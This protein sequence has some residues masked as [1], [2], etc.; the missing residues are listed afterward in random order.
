MGLRK[1][2][3]AVKYLILYAVIFFAVPVTFSVASNLEVERYINPSS[4]VAGEWANVEIIVQGFEV[5]LE[6]PVPFDGV[7]IIDQSRSM[8]GSDPHDKR[9]AAAKTF[10]GGAGAETRVAIVTISDEGRM[11]QSLTSNRQTLINK[12]N[13]LDGREGGATNI[14]DAMIKAQEELIS[15]GIEIRKKVIVLLTDGYPTPDTDDQE[16]AI[17]DE[18]LPEANHYDIRYYTVGLG[19]WADRVL[20]ELI[21]DRTGGFY[22][23]T[24][25]E[26]LADI[27]VYIGDE[28]ARRVCPRQVVVK[29]RVNPQLTVRQGSLSWQPDLYTISEAQQD[30][31]YNTGRINVEMGELGPNEHRSLTF[32]V[33]ALCLHPDSEQDRVEIPVGRNG[34]KIEYTLGNVTGEVQIPQRIL[35]CLKPGEIEIRKGFD[36]ATSIC[37]LAVKSKYLDLPDRD[38]TIRNIRIF[39]APSLYFQP[40]IRSIRP[41]PIH[42]FPSARVDYIYWSIPRL[43]PG[44]EWFAV[45]ELIPRACSP[46]HENPF[47][48]NE[49]KELGPAP[50]WFSYISPDGMLKREELPQE[51]VDLVYIEECDGRPDLFITPAV[52]LHEFNYKPINPREYVPPEYESEAIWIDSEVNGFVQDWTDLDHVQASLHGTYITYPQQ[53]KV[54][55]QGDPFPLGRRNVVYALVYNKGLQSSPPTQAMLFAHNWIMRSWDLVAEISIPPIQAWGEVLI[56]FELPQMTLKNWY[57]FPYGVPIQKTLSVL[58]SHDRE[59]CSLTSEDFE[60]LP[61]LDRFKLDKTPRGLSVALVSALRSDRRLSSWW[62][63]TFATLKISIVPVSLERHT[64][65]NSATEKVIVSNPPQLG[66]HRPPP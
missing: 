10:L 31:F 29:E 18:I 26:G 14:R 24:T 20:L 51:M 48:I 33:G 15:N 65:N 56:K 62:R 11:V 6:E 41:A 27:Y 19:D 34:A 49:T 30:D 43:E 53:I 60:K 17:L 5:L 2:H 12:I 7:L 45:F 4:I 28:A 55:G 35:E 66:R 23:P 63:T 59:F 9:L 36:P 1:K 64:N 47:Q 40:L 37:T 44:A 8:D 39:E 50:G 25:P 58:C 16:N 46:M 54:K 52:T 13:G 61:A 38:N 32:D 42:V 3:A 57:L 22:S 21:A